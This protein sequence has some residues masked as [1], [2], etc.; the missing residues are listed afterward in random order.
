M[1][2]WKDNKG[3]KVLVHKTWDFNRWLFKYFLQYLGVLVDGKLDMSQQCALTAQKANHTLGCI[4]KSTASRLREMS[5]P[6]YSV[7]V[8][9][10]QEYCTH[11]GRPQ[12]RRC[13]EI[14][15]RIQRR[16]TKM[17]QGNR[18]PTDV[19][20]AP[21]LKTFK[22]RL[23]QVLGNLMELCCPCVLQGRWTR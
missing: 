21:S 4:Q 7:L 23:D 15:E 12:Y 5:L 10:H 20:D 22:V 6:F 9:P 2:F 14:L 1:D 18:L 3:R 11:T 13:M 19:V 8:G 16:A 17:I